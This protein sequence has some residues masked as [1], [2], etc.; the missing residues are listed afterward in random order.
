MQLKTTSTIIFYL[1]YLSAISK[2]ALTLLFSS[3]QLREERLFSLFFLNCLI[4]L[5][6]IGFIQFKNRNIMDKF[7]LSI[8]ENK[9]NLIYNI[10]IAVTL[11]LTL[12]VLSIF[13]SFMLSFI[14]NDFKNAVFEYIS[15]FIILSLPIV[16]LFFRNLQKY[17]PFVLFIIILSIYYFYIYKYNSDYEFIFKKQGIECTRDDQLSFLFYPIYVKE[18]DEILTLDN[19]K[20]IS[21]TTVS[22]FCKRFDEETQKSEFFFLI[23]NQIYKYKD[24]TK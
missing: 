10:F 1:I 23:D 21:K 22:T 11:V 20:E 18:G 14:H 8:K 6:I 12:L 24:E 5:L 13:I 2:I 7:F 19:K 16:L 4:Y 9:I 17:F 3:L 15:L